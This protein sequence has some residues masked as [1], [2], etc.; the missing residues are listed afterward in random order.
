ML[1]EMGNKPSQT[2]STGAIVPALPAGANAEALPARNTSRNMQSGN[3]TGITVAEEP[4]DV[5][6]AQDGGRRRR[7]RKGRKSHTHR[8][9]Q[10]KSRSTRRSTHRKSRRQH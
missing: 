2:G 1:E 9:S 6:V 4:I 5:V 7:G 8:K 10:R 3:H